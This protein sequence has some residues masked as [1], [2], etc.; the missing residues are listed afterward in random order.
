MKK[1]TQNPWYV[2]ILKCADGTLYT[3]V[4]TDPKRRVQEHNHSPLGA[5]YTKP[6]RPVMLI[7][8]EPHSSRTEATKREAEIKKLSRGEKVKLCSNA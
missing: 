5:K 3:G 1:L 7:Y 8:Q 4:T 6:R 2:Y